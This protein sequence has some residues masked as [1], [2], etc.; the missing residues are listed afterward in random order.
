MIDFG[1]CF[2]TQIS[3]CILSIMIHFF[4]AQVHGFNFQVQRAYMFRHLA[5]STAHDMCG[6]LLVVDGNAKAVR[7]RCSCRVP[8]ARDAHDGCKSDTAE[9]FG[10][11]CPKTPMRGDKQRRCHTCVGLGNVEVFDAVSTSSGLRASAPIRAASKKPAKATNNQPAD[12]AEKTGHNGSRK[13]Q[14]AAQSS[15]DKEDSD[16]EGSDP[17]RNSDE[18]PAMESAGRWQYGPDNSDAETEVGPLPLRLLSRFTHSHADHN[19]P[20]PSTDRQEIQRINAT[21]STNRATPC[22][23]TADCILQDQF[24]PTPPATMMYRVLWSGLPECDSTWEEYQA[25]GSTA[26]G[27]RLMNA[28]DAKVKLSVGAFDL[29]EDNLV[30]E[31]LYADDSDLVRKASVFHHCRLSGCSVIDLSGMSISDNIP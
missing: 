18:D 27:H 7:S 29:P 28:W 6:M 4:V 22:F 14:V 24:D 5:T 11:F 1:P 12:N 31:P 19:L 15:S 17:D 8:Y 23:A 13:R 21:M 20:A 26:D 9:F 16:T 25:F 2:P 10:K 3:C 30:L